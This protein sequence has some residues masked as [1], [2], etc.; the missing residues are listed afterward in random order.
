MKQTIHNK[1]ERFAALSQHFIIAG[2][3]VGRVSDVKRDGTVIVSFLSSEV[4]SATEALS[5]FS[6]YLVEQRLTFTQ[7]EDNKIRMLLP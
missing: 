1:R 6:N 7:V 5:T 3:E 2:V 4:T